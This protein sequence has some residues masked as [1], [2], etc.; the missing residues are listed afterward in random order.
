M[1]NRSSVKH[2]YHKVVKNSFNRSTPVKAIKEFID[3]CLDVFFAA[4][5][6]DAS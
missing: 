4:L 3:V 5:M 6:M 1:V 2:S